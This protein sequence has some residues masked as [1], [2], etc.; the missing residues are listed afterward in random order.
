[1]SR[2][3]AD[4]V[5]HKFDRTPGL[6]PAGLEDL[7][8]D[9]TAERTLKAEGL[10]APPTPD[11]MKKWRKDYTPGKQ[12]SHPGTSDDLDYRRLEVY[13]RSEPVGVKVHDAPSHTHPPPTPTHPRTHPHR[14]PTPKVHDVLN[15]APKSYLLEKAVQK[16]EQIYLSHKREPLGKQYLR[17]HALPAELVESG[18][19]RPT[20][21]DISGDP[22]KRMLHPEERIAPEAEAA[23]YRTSHSHFAPGEQRHRGYSWVDGEGGGID[24]A[25]YRFGGIV[26]ERDVNGMA[27]AMNPARDERVPRDPI[28]VGKLLEDFREVHGEPLGRVRNLGFGA[29]GIDTTT[30]VFGLP[31]QRGPEW[32]ARECMGNYTAEEQAPD[33]D[34]GRSLKPGWRN[35]APPGRMFGVP[36][37]RKDIAAPSMKSV[38]DHQNYGDESGAETL[39]YPPRFID[40]G[41]AQ[42][43]FLY[44][45]SKAEIA[46]IFQ[47]A[48]F[49]LSEAELAAVYERATAFDAYGAVSVESFRR[50]LNSMC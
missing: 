32:G 8:S 10:A 2:F 48:G 36:S 33:K 20:P 16:R 24:P 27:K 42:E 30:H 47:S 13:G 50:T 3:C 45:R 35:I 5:A 4:R 19:G 23:L 39:L 38:A 14:P 40:E 21:Q 46:D 7:T 29:R 44:A 37:I 41:V 31:S 28:V 25:E 49:E 12:C 18:F 17:G 26:T 9:E 11:H 22:T 34:L 1:M 15:V 6:P 43:D